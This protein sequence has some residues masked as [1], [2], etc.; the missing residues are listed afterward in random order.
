MSRERMTAGWLPEAGVR[1]VR[2]QVAADDH[3]GMLHGA[4]RVEQPG[5]NGGGAGMRGGIA[6]ERG[7]PAGP[8]LG[9]VVQQAHPR[10]PGS[11]DA[12]VAGLAET[13]LL[14]MGEHLD[15]RVGGEP[16]RRVVGAGVIDDEHTRT[17]GQLGGEQGIQAAP[18]Q[19]PAA[20][21]RDDDRHRARHEESPAAA[22]PG[23]GPEAVEARAG[24]DAQSR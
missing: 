23:A 15:T 14:G 4:V 20:V 21:H 1:V 16:R 19:R 7:E 8:G 3:V 22:T 24:T 6:R 18:G 13:G 9:V 11:G 5:P 2:L 12:V 10:R 17:F